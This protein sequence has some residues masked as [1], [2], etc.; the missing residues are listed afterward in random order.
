MNEGL[1]RALEPDLMCVPAYLFPEKLAIT[2]GRQIIPGVTIC[3][4]TGPW[5]EE[6][7]SHLN[8]LKTH[9]FEF[10]PTHIIRIRTDDYKK[11][12]VSRIRRDGSEFDAKNLRLVEYNGI[13]KQL[14]LSLMLASGLKF[15]FRG[16]FHFRADSGETMGYRMTSFGNSPLY[17]ASDLVW[18][19]AYKAQLRTEWT[20]ASRIALKVDRYFRSGV[21]WSDRLSMGIQYFWNALCSSIPEQAFLSLM[22]GL[23]SVL[24]TQRTEITHLLSE[25][26][27]I[28]LGK[29]RISRLRIYKQMKKLY[30]IRS[31]LVHGKAFTRRGKQTTESLIVSAK[32]SNVPHS[33]MGELVNITGS[34]IKCLLSRPTYLRIVQTK[35]NEDKTSQEL[36]TYFLKQLFS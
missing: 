25:R 12:V 23:E 5:K 1:L 32:Y 21:W 4:L 9:Q 3:S 28:I 35:R 27:A 8:R 14:M 6:I 24:S 15:K 36:D 10:H 18:G 17:A 29:G 11:E 33:A 7:L 19:A 30:G 20:Q 16:C 2:K 31:E 26:V 22:S 34:V 13:S